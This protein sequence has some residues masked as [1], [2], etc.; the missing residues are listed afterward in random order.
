M[1][2]LYSNSTFYIFMAGNAS[3]SVYVKEIFDEYIS[4]DEPKAQALLGVLQGGNMPKF[5]I[6]PPLGT[7][8]A[9]KIINA[10]DERTMDSI[11]ASTVINDDTR[12]N[13]S[14][15]S[16]VKEGAESESP[17][18]YDDNLE[19]QNDENLLRPTGKT[20]VA[21]GLLETCAGGSIKVVNITNNI[22]EEVA[23]QYYIG[24]SRKKKFYTVLGHGA[25]YNQWVDFMDAS[26]DFDI[27]YTTQ[28]AAANNNA[29]LNIAKRKHIVLEKKVPDGRVFIRPVSS[30][31]IVYTIAKSME[32]CANIK[33][34]GEL[35]RI[36]F[37]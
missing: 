35:V 17:V 6:L 18:Q 19:S 7:V 23:F 33:D 28:P 22:N 16:A 5:K 13:D 3:K 34:E 14:H 10:S 15:T 1:Y 21:Y 30:T 36:D 26:D 37:E 29:S 25:S 9:D 2:Y 31:A 11:E 4:G 24:R 8:E 27:L 20:G 32:E 12:E